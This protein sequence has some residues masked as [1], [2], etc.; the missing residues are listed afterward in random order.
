MSLIFVAEVED[1]LETEIPQIKKSSQ[2]F[3]AR[4]L[5]IK[6]TMRCDFKRIR[7]AQTRELE[8][9]SVGEDVEH[10]YRPHHCRWE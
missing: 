9:A 3:V 8:N 10:G 2:R 5:E 1:K 7:Q 4:E 6:I